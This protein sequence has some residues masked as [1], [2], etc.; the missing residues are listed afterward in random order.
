MT[1]GQCVTTLGAAFCVVALAAVSPSFADSKADPFSAPGQNGPA[2]PGAACDRVNVCATPGV[3]YNGEA[4]AGMG[5]IWRTNFTDGVLELWDVVNCT[6]LAR[7]P[8]P[9]AGVGTPSELTV[10]G[11][12]LYHYNFGT[13]LIY[14]IDTNTCQEVARCDA[15]GNDLGEG[16]T[17]DGTYLWRSDGNELI[18]FT[19]PTA[20]AG[21]QIVGRCP[22]PAGDA[23]D[24]LTM[25]KDQ[26]VMLGYSG[27]LYTI[28]P[29][30]CRITGVCDLNAGA[31]GNGLAGNR[32]D[33]VL[34]DNDNGDLDR[35]DVG[36]DIPVPLENS[37]WGGVKALHR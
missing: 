14:A 7:C 9:A 13:G 24:G 32:S 20:A 17:N 4:F 31:T 34:A 35:V 33:T 1:R 28:D 10:I 21:C 23:G 18:Q 3:V 19:P 2:T 12:I 22:L 16:L 30:T 11:D 5:R 26:L 25:C 15:P 36:C 6:I 29:V 37:T 27:T 8:D